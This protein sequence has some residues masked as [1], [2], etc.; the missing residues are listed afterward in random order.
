[1]DYQPGNVTLLVLSSFQTH[2]ET[3]VC[4]ILVIYLTTFSRS[5]RFPRTSKTDS[6]YEM[7]QLESQP[8]LLREIESE[9]E[10]RGN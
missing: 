6:Q 9:D 10:W 7:Y 3:V 2:M 8:F 5:K 1:M 4:Q